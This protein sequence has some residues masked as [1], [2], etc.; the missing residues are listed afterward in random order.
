MVSAVWKSCRCFQFAQYTRMK[1]PRLLFVGVYYK[2]HT[3]YICISP[4]F[5]TFENMK[6]IFKTRRDEI[7]LRKITSNP[8]W[9]NK[10]AR[11]Y[12]QLYLQ[13]WWWKAICSPKRWLT[14]TGLHGI[15]VSRCSAV[16]IA[17]GWTTEESSSSPGRVK[18]FPFSKSPRPVLGSTKP[19][20][21]WVP[22][23]NGRGVKLTIHLQIVPKYVALYIHSPIRF[24][25]VVG[26]TLTFLY[27]ITSH[28]TELFKILW[29]F[30]FPR[31]HS[32]VIK[33]RRKVLTIYN[34]EVTNFL[35]INMF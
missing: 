25:G 16:G 13:P 12:E 11:Y 22:G 8:T 17:T 7:F 29:G 24:H 19:P 30:I 10:W 31:R 9:Q 5:I 27:G 20:I 15:T 6:L 3:P 18:N 23:V 1:L 26:A 2:Y 34:D 35:M 4:S 33:G 28:E 21:Q 14:F 32:H